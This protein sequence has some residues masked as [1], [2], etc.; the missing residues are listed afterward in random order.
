MS[1]LRSGC[2]H[3]VSFTVSPS[4]LSIAHITF[5]NFNL[6]GTLAHLMKQPPPWPL[7]SMTTADILFA[8]YERALFASLDCFMTVALSLLWLHCARLYKKHITVPLYSTKIVWAWCHLKQT[9]KRK[10]TLLRVFRS[11]TLPHFVGQMCIM[12]KNCEWVFQY[13]HLLC[14]KLKQHPVLS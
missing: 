3:A 1:G 6:G 7:L 12:N 8:H 9:K 2:H 5:Q 13:L 11:H 14:L 4:A 10:N